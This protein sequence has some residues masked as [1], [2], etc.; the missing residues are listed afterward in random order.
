MI[1]H[2]YSADPRLTRMRIVPLSSLP[3]PNPAMSPERTPSILRSIRSS[4][5][6][7]K[8]NEKMLRSLL[9][10]MAHLNLTGQIELEGPAKN[11]H[12][13]YCDMFIGYIKGPK[14]SRY[15]RRNKVA[16]KRLRVHILAERDF[17]KVFGHSDSLFFSLICGMHDIY[18][19]LPR[20]SASGHD[21][22]IQTYWFLLDMH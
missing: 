12:G 10:S 19:C 4:A 18:R 20:K 1:L 22:I 11:A 5:S 2:K 13:G 6:I 8:N 9:D 7:S 15:T 14:A 21:S 17:A 16:I 3:S